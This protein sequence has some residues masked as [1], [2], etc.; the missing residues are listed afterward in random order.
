MSRQENSKISTT[1]CFLRRGENFGE[2]GLIN[3]RPR[4]ACVISKEPVELL[5]FS[6]E[7]NKEIFMSG[8]L[9]NTQHSFF[10]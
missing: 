1:V 8:G 6:D 5:V 10:R 4:R 7:D 9:K 2:L 3:R